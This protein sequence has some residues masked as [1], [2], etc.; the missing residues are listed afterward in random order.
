MRLLY[1][2]EEIGRITT[3]HSITIEEACEL[4]NIDLNEE[5]GGDSVWDYELFS[6]DSL[7]EI[8]T[9]TEIKIIMLVKQAKRNK[10]IAEIMG[11]TEGTVRT[12]LRSI[13]RKLKIKSRAE[14]IIKEL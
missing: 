3:N 14:L 9:P 12:H 1:D 5:D 8:F 7:D 13:F 11:I 6:F 10:E 2:S 4:L